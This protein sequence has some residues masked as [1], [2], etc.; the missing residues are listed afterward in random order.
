[1]RE[2]GK[3]NKKRK[4]EFVVEPSH[5]GKNAGPNQKEHPRRDCLDGTSWKKK[6]TKKKGINA[7][8]CR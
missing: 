4:K 1:L 2:E 3:E 6:E 8:K 7:K 5:I